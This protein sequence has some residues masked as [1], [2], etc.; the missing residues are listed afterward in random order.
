VDIGTIIGI[1][2]GL[3]L[4]LVSI[5]LKASILAFFDLASILIVVGG[6]FA[7]TFV[8]FPMKSVLNALKAAISIFFLHKIDPVGT[9]RE[10]LKAA[11]EV[12]RNGPLALEKVKASNQFMKTSFD[13]V[14]D[15]MNVD[16]IRDVLTIELEATIS[17][18]EEV[19]KILEKMSDLAPA[20]GMIGTLI[21]L[22]IML[23]NLDDPSAIGPAM[24]VALLTTF[25]GALWANL[26]LTPSAAKLEDRSER[27]AQEQRLI[28]EGALG[29]AR[30][31]N[32]R[33]IQQRLVGFMPSE[34]RAALQSKAMAKK[35]GK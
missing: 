16:A 11:D 1:V 34:D 9:V 14:A 20:W 3:I 32:P 17:R 5:I 22:V 23:L 18:N 26:L 6:T 25:Y 33:A 28:L 21:G 13:L 15:G 24:A 29:M 12:R 8:A 19:V 7:A 2:V 10:I 27:E 31:E 4:V 30:N 35:K